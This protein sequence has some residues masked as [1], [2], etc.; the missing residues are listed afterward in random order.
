MA[1]R[2]ESSIAYKG[3]IPVVTPLPWIQPSAVPTIA[4]SSSI[5]SRQSRDSCAVDGQAH[6]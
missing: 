5:Y 1:S 2:K 4:Y 3:T 6:S